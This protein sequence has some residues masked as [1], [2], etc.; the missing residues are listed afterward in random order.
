[1]YTNVR[2]LYSFL[3]I[4]SILLIKCS[5]NFIYALM[6]Y[7]AWYF[8][9]FSGSVDRIQKK[10]PI[11]LKE[12]CYKGDSERLKQNSNLVLVGSFSDWH[13]EKWKSNTIYC[14][15]GTIQSV[16]KDYKYS[17]ERLPSSIEKSTGVKRMYLNERTVCPR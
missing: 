16:F 2:L 4:F 3:F 8:Y 14:L 15:Y 9:F 11:Y 1:M 7:V 6:P 17:D 13:Y 10:T 5:M 12:N